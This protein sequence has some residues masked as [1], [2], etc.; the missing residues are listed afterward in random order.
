MFEHSITQPSAQV[1]VVVVPLHPTEDERIA[2]VLGDLGECG[3]GGLAIRESSEAAREVGWHGK[4]RFS[5]WASDE[6]E[7]VLAMLFERC[8]DGRL[9]IG[10][11]VRPA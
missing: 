7:T 3:R 4:T 6:K 1:R 8:S 10:W 9:D 2:L 5:L 11:R